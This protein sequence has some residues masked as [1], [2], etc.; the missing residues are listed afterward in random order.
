[1][2]RKRSF[3]VILAFVVFFVSFCTLLTSDVFAAGSTRRYRVYDAN[4]AAYKRTYTLTTQPRSNISAYT[5]YGNDSREIDWTKNGVVKIVTTTAS[6]PGVEGLGTGFVVDKHVIATA[7]HLL[8]SSGSLEK[9]MVT[10][11]DLFDA[12]DSSENN[13]K[14]TLS[15]TPVEYHIPAEFESRNDEYYDD[16]NGKYDPTQDYALI[17][18]K[19]DLSQ[20]MCF[21]IANPL[22]TFVSENGQNR[23]GNIMTTGFPGNV[24]G[25]PDANYTKNGAYTGYGSISAINSEYLY[26]N[27]DTS[28]GNSGG[29]VY[30]RE[31]VGDRMYYTVIGI[32]VGYASSGNI[33]IR[34]TPD[35][36][37]F[38]GVNPNINY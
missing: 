15:A 6:D 7:A 1:M 37:K 38:Y 4:T 25:E 16:S 27:I 23:S 26:Y 30:L 35:I 2:I 12:S 29:P 8:V 11:I 3:T 19:E 10:S 24:T 17:T 36:L 33:G 18:V 21:G 28:N 9:H 22:D 14:P 20:Y 34:M 5:I 13:R 32:N 31:V